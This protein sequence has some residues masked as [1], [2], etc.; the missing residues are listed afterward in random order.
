MEG[1]A[2][3]RRREKGRG[4]RGRRIGRGNY[5]G[6]GGERSGGGGGSRHVGSAIYASVMTVMSP[7]WV[8]IHTSKHSNTIPQSS[9]H[10]RPIKL[11]RRSQ[12]SLG[13]T[14]SLNW[15]QHFYT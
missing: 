7:I 10:L 14:P 6:G 2:P 5:E 12:L 1:E 4:K 8:I 3:R 11:R 13:S 15:I 9:A